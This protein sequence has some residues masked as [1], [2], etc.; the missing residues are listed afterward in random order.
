VVPGL[1][2]YDAEVISHVK[3]LRPSAR[4]EL[5]ITDLNQTYLARKTLKVVALPR[6]FAWLDAG[7]TSSLHEASSY[8]QTLEKRQGIKIGCPEEAA[9]QAGLIDRAQFRALFEKMPNCEYRDYLERIADST[10]LT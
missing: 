8:I 2:A 9:L 3:K 7:T 10:G 1:Y 6:G 5:E 4:N